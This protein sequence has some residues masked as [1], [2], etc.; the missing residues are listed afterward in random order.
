V[1]APENVSVLV[2]TYGSKEWEER[3]AATAAAAYNYL[4]KDG[5]REVAH[6]HLSE[7]TLAQARNLAAAQ[8][9]GT[10]LC[11]LDGDDSLS[12]DYA[13][14]V[15]SGWADLRQPKTTYS[16]PDGTLR[17]GVPAFIPPAPG[18]DLRKGN[19]LVIGTAVRRAMFEEVGGFDEYEAWEDFALWLKCVRA[20]AEIGK[21][22]RA[23]YHIGPVK[24]GDRN[25]QTIGNKALF[26]KIVKEC[27]G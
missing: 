25:Q 18:G 3:G 13:R 22:P 11:F 17:L 7:G 26:D 14:G 2:S 27:S 20:G 21:A 15:L 4:K 23:I 6:V 19:W 12:P 9:R 24:P 8:A 16:N 5:L 1:T 10:W